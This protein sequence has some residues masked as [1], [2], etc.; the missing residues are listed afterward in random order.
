MLQLSGVEWDAVYVDFFKGANRG[1]A[2]LALNSMGEVPILEH[3]GKTLS[4]SGVILDYLANRLG[5]FG[6]Q[7]ED[8]SREI[9][10]WILWDNH[11]LTGHLATY[12]FITNFL[13]EEKRS[14]DV[15]A[16]LGGRLAAALKALER[17]LTNRDWIVGSDLTIADLSCAGYFFYPGEWDL[18]TEAYPNIAAWAERIRKTP[19]W[20]PPYDLMPGHPAPA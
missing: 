16:F 18:E 19:G 4:Q 11:K 14:A 12:R 7:N 17:H 9:M 6:A 15:I 20:I 3:D 1:E 13:P 5:Q 8:E 10:R 2:F